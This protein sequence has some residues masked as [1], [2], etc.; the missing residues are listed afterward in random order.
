MGIYLPQKNNTSKGSG[1]QT[2][3]QQIKEIRTDVFR[4]ALAFLSQSYGG[5]CRSITMYVQILDTNLLHNSFILI[6]LIP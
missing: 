2:L 5:C 1:L 4:S 6:Y 3:V